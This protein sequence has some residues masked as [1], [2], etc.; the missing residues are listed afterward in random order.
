M[1]KVFLYISLFF[2]STSL[3]SAQSLNQARSEFERFEFANCV[4]IYQDLLVTEGLKKKDLELLTYA[5]YM[6]SDWGYCLSIVDKL[7]SLGSIQPMYLLMKADALKHFE[8][9]DEAKVAYAR[10]AKEDKD[11]DV[12]L[13]IASCD[14]LRTLEAERMLSVNRLD[15]NTKKADAFYFDAELGMIIFHE[16]GIDSLYSSLDLVK[17]NDAEL[18]LMRPFVK[19]NSEFVAIDFPEKLKNFSITSFSK[20]S[21]SD[22]AVFTVVDQMNQDV[23]LT[24]PQ[25]FVGKLNGT[26]V[27]QVQP[28]KFSN[29]MGG[30]VTANG[31]FAPKSNDLIFA[32]ITDSTQMT[33]LFISRYQ[34]NDWSKPTTLSGINT[35]GDDVYPHFIGNDF[36][37]SSTGRLGY[38]ALDVYSGKFDLNSGTVSEI[39]HLTKPI[40]SSFDDYWYVNFQDTAYISSNRFGSGGEDDIWELLPIIEEIAVVTEE[41][42][43]TTKEINDWVPPKIYFVLAKD[44]PNTDYTFLNKVS[45]ILAENKGLRINVVG[46][47]DVRGSDELNQKLS[48]QRASFVRQ[49]LIKLGIPA[50]QIIA[51]GEGEKLAKTNSVEESSEKVHQ[52][53]RFVSITLEYNR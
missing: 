51:T 22:F 39:I 8:R 25:L 5:S 27:T 12:S 37:F 30:I 50:N 19:A 45:H 10:Y 7:D 34:N 1:M 49:E 29:L 21:V 2:A 40:N 26:K 36:Y 41:E 31:V 52:A 35:K 44:I 24:S 46:Y 13:D 42:I 6:S 16:L 23:K 48:E 20:S 15:Y 53:N 3:V 4:K 38:G 18:L 33:D 43:K 28:W 14:Y 32:S 17:S 11:D 47:T 9:Y